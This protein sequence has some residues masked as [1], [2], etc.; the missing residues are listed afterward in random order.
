MSDN[1]KSLIGLLLMLDPQKRLTA[2]GVLDFLRNTMTAW[3][4]GEQFPHNFQVIQACPYDWTRGT[5][6]DSSGK[7]NGNETSCPVPYPNPNPTSGT[8]QWVHTHLA[9]HGIWRILRTW[10]SVKST[11]IPWKTF[12]LAGVLKLTFY[13]GAMLRKSPFKTYRP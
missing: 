11:L 4:V 9:S 8:V 10:M 3:W 13:D 2:S 6:S 12:K 1:T 5:F 7:I